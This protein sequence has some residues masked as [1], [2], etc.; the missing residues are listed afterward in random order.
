M[1]RSFDGAYWNQE[2]ESHTPKNLHKV[3]VEKLFVKPTALKPHKYTVF[4]TLNKQL[5]VIF[6]HLL[7]YRK[8]TTNDHENKKELRHYKT[9][10]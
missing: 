8:K 9:T 2:Y 6:Y 4:E 3:P 5:E 1:N 7:Q 10:H